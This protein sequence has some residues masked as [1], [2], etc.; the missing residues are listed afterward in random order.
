MSTRSY[1]KVFRAACSI[2]PTTLRFATDL[3]TTVSARQRLDAQQQ[4]NFSVQKEFKKLNDETNIYKIVGPVLLK[5]ERAEATSAVDGRLEYIGGEMSEVPA[6]LFSY[7]SLTGC[8]KRRE[9][10][11]KDLQDKSDQKR[12]QVGHTPSR[13]MSTHRLIML[14]GD[15]AADSNTTAATAVR[16]WTSA[17]SLSVSLVTL[18]PTVRDMPWLKRAEGQQR[19]KWPHDLGS[20]Q[21]SAHIEDTVDVPTQSCTDERHCFAHVC[22]VTLCSIQCS[23]SLARI[24]EAL[25]GCRELR[26][27][28]QEALQRCQ[29][30]L[31]ALHSDV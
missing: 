24:S 30:Q 26:Q 6:N 7:F 23:R 25:P 18:L 13:P 8:S 31:L 4:E 5:Q 12:T 2:S 20:S 21:R 1:K 14:S 17:A 27:T 9:G 16:C 15:P 3:Q 28:L 22:N 11:L 19:G 10:Q 29:V